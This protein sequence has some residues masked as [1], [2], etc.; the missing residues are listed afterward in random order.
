MHRIIPAILP[1]SIS[2]LTGAA[3]A[4]TFAPTVQID[5][6]DGTFASP[7]TWPYQPQGV[8]TEAEAVCERYEVQVDIMAVD[9]YAMAEA[10]VAAGAREIVVHIETTADLDPFKALRQKHGVTL[11]LSGNDTLP[12]AEFAHHHADI[13]GVQ[14]MGIET[15]GMQ[16]QPLSPRVIDNIT[17]LRAAA[18]A[19]PIQIDGSVNSETISSLAAAGAKDFVVGSAIVGATDPRSAYQ[20]LT[21]ALH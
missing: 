11:L 12:V 21:A 3:A 18:P 15:I 7:A 4:M 20:A 14:L 13:D 17:A 9:P 5:I 19:L 16:G 8:P 1:S 6:V 2:E 10:W